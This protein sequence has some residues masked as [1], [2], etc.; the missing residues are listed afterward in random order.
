MFIELLLMVSVVGKAEPQA[1]DGG[2]SKVCNFTVL[3]I[4][5]VNKEVDTVNITFPITKTHK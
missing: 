4:D 1:I 5:A 2:L 3:K